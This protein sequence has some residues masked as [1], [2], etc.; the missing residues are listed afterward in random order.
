M[1]TTRRETTV[2]E[3]A[4]N[5]AKSRLGLLERTT[6]RSFNEA[7]DLPTETDEEHS[8]H[9]RE[10]LDM[11]LNYEKIMEENK[12]REAEI[13]AEAQRIEE[14]RRF[15]ESEARAQ[16]R[17]RMAAVQV[18]E[19]PQ[20]AEETL[21]TPSGTTMQFKTDNVGELYNDLEKQQVK[22][23]QKFR[24][25]AHGKLLAAIYAIVVVTILA[26]II[27]NTSVL[28]SIRNNNAEKAAMLAEKQAQYAKVLEEY[29]YVSSDDYVIKQAT[30]EYGMVK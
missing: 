28:A 18:E 8:E 10:N 13:A 2:E 19:K 11:I 27:I 20:V 6:A 7:Y 4:R 26:L 22:E 25:N 9:A 30:D 23:N 3:M 5:E 17:V 15:A 29:N 24:L 16:E 12:R 21:V 14:T 1:I